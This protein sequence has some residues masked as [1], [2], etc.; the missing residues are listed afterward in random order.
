MK[1]ACLLEEIR[2]VTEPIPL[3]GDALAQDLANRHL[4][5]VIRA[6]GGSRNI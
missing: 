4:L 1:R 3:E 5:G 6:L 2:Q